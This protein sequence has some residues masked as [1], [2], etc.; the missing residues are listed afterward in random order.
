MKIRFEILPLTPDRWKD[1]VELFGPRGACGGC[2]CMWWRIPRREFEANKGAANRR[3]FRRIVASG[4]VPGLMAYHEGTPVG[5]CC[6]GP[7]ERFPVLERSRVLRRVDDLPVWSIVCFFIARPWRRR[8]VAAALVA[9]AVR[10][11]FLRGAPAVEAYP[12][13]PRGG[14]MPDAFAWTGVASLF[15]SAGFAEAARRS[16]ARSIMRR[17]RRSGAGRGRPIARGSARATEGSAG[18]SCS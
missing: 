13:E 8:G 5:W 6:V 1:V 12:V 14:T 16:A 10:H 7:R 2:W 11:A 9:G 4:E 17:Y 15:R 18:K 3:S